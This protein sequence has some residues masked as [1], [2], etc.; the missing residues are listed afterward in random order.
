MEHKTYI[1]DEGVLHQ[2]DYDSPDELK[3]LIAE[4]W[5]SALLD[6]GVGKTV[7]GKIWLDQFIQNLDK[8]DQDQIKFSN[9]SHIYQFGD[10]RNIKAIKSNQIPAV[11]GSKKFQI[12]TDVIEGDIPPSSVQIVNEKRKYED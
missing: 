8:I 3:V 9:S 4:S 5:S 12:E 2:N 6:C 11:I 1:A 10:G 7:F